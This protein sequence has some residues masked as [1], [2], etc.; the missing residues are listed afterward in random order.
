MSRPRA[1]WEDYL[2]DPGGTVADLLRA[3]A[4]TVLTTAALWAPVLAVL[5]V[6]SGVAAR[7]WRRARHDRIV[8]GHSGRRMA[9][10]GAHA[11]VAGEQVGARRVT[12]L[13]PPGVT[14]PAVR[15]CGPTW[16]VCCGP[17]GA[18]SC[19]ASRTWCGS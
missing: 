15:R 10:D 17:G 5:L 8:T 9:L 1:W 13:A 11:G 7:S 2:R 16:S 18:A 19:S 4:D 12:V 6:V 3:A 14:R